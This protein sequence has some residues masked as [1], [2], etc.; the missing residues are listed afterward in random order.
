MLRLPPL[1]WTR[2]AVVQL[3]LTDVVPLV[4]GAICG[5]VLGTSKG[6]YLVLQVF[7]VIGG[8]LAG[9][10]HETAAE[11][12]ARGEVAGLLFGTGILLAHGLA[13]TKAKA[14]LPDP[15]ILLIVITTVGGVIL[16]ALGARLRA[17][18]S[19]SP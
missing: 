15:E 4:Y 5:V 6:V 13:K 3:L 10:E 1:L 12:A 9:F 8:V 17:G 11:G 16:G 14:S 7:A 19:A 18:R 2:P